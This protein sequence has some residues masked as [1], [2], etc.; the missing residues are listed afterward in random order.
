MDFTKRELNNYDLEL[1]SFSFHWLTMTQK[2]VPPVSTRTVFRGLHC[3]YQVSVYIKV[4]VW[5][6][7]ALLPIAFL[8]LPFFP[9]LFQVPTPVF[10]RM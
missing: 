5:S 1:K 10:L 9:S 4:D 2:K 7:T 3:G 6:L 8:V